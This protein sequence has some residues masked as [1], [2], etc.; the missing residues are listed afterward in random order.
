MLSALALATGA[1]TKIAPLVALP[2]LMR[3]WPWRA[4]VAAL[5]VLVPGLAWF[6]ELARG[7]ASGLHAFWSA[8]SN[9]ELAFHYLEH[10]LGDVAARGVAFALLAALMVWAFRTL[11]D[12]TRATRLSL[13]GA[14]LLSPVLHPWYMGWVLAFEPLAPS[15][16]WLLLSLTAIL[17]YGVLATPAQGRDFHLPLAWR[18]AEYGAP[19]ALALLLALAARRSAG[20]MP[21][22]RAD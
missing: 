20:T 10:G 1:L 16:P 6:L 17:N 5:A 12:A 22:S 18:W 11:P 2:F 15:Y 8:W 19:L 3:G 14:L 13:R 4:R 21:K 9:N 7:P